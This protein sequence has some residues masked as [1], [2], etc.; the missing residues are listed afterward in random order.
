MTHTPTL[1]P[2]EIA[3]EIRQYS[4]FAGFDEPLLLQISTM[5]REVNFLAGTLILTSGKM[6]D[7]L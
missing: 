7:Q 6:N 3:K 2:A 1:H 4:F 5:V